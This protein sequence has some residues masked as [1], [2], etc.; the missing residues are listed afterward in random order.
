MTSRAAAF[1]KGSL[2]FPLLWLALLGACFLWAYWPTLQVL[3][4]RW[5]L[6]PQYSH[7]YVVPLFALL[8]LWVRRR[9]ALR[10]SEGATAAAYPVLAPNPHLPWLPGAAILAGG[11]VMRLAGAY[12]YFDW[13]DA[14]SLLPSLAGLCLLLGGWSV[15]RWTWPAV[16]FLVFMIPLPY[17]AE[18]ALSHPLQRVATQASAYSLQTV[19][20]PALTEGNVI[21]IGETRIGVAE[22]CSGLS[23]LLVFIALALA[24]ALVL[25]RPLWIRAA[26]VV[27]A[28]PIAVLANVIRITLTGVLY[29]TAGRGLADV[30]YHDAAGWLMMPVALLLV[31]IEVCFLDRLF[32][33][34]APACSLPIG[35]ADTKP[36]EQ[37]VRPG[38]RG[39]ARNG[40]RP[41]SSP[42]PLF[43][44]P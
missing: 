36:G 9:N 42:L 33:A 11:A 7:G 43:P 5:G 1:F 14:L 23:M 13:F 34:P 24:I 15:L 32:I 30:F 40:R 37:G 39:R 17:Q 26:L 27:S 8:V 18:L 41:V 2:R 16:A 35:L 3:A 12:L 28:V 20:F 38:A 19:G 4:H 21:A 10:Q 25:S 22:A 29:Q 31:G 6:D 44:A